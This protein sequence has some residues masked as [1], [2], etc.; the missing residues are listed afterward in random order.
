MNDVMVDMIKES[1]TY[2]DVF[3]NGEKVINGWSKNCEE[4]WNIIK[5]FIKSGDRI[6]DI[7]SYHGYFS[8][9]A[10]CKTEDV[11]VLSFE[12][13]KKIA[14]AQEMILRANHIDA[15]Q[16]MLVKE[17]LLLEDLETFDDRFDIAFVLNVLH[18]F[19]DI[20]R[21]FELLAKS[22]KRGAIIE[23]PDLNDVMT[24]YYNVVEELS[25]LDKYLKKY[26]KSVKKIGEVNAPETKDGKRLLFFAKH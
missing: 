26:F 18:Y 22:V 5:P 10:V 20:P 23:F 4:R 19:N 6:L 11:S 14:D 15:E 21:F 12:G 17:N 2:Q 1:G 25:P 7:G 16:I 13:D 8:I 24:K 3:I 9:R